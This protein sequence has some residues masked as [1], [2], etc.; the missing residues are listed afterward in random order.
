MI[1]ATSKDYPS[2][3][4]VEKQIIL[5]RKITEEIWKELKIF[6][7]MKLFKD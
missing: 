2:I 5:I 6:E 1:V 3:S 4:F 7:E